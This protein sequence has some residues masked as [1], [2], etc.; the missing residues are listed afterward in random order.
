MA[1][2]NEREKVN[3][4]DTVHVGPGKTIPKARAEALGLLD[5]DGDVKEVELDTSDAVAG[6]GKHSVRGLAAATGQ[7]VAAVR[8]DLARAQAESGTDPSEPRRSTK[9]IEPDPNVALA[10][11]VG[12]GHDP[13]KQ[14]S[15]TVQAVLDDA[16]VRGIIEKPMD[17]DGI[18]GAA[19][20]EDQDGV[21][22]L[23][24]TRDGKEQK[25]EATTV[26]DPSAARR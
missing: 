22:T 3:D 24:I 4:A 10:D 15:G 5:D 20:R 8:A 16:L 2:D 23:F 19:I 25:V 1:Q 26:V 18:E 17:S 21:K 14:T 13:G 11:A 6:D 7:S 9:V 12:E